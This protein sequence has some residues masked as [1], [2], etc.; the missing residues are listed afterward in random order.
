MIGISDG[1][2]AD[3]KW[4]NTLNRLRIEWVYRYTSARGNAIRTRVRAKVVVERMILLHQHNKV[5]DWG[6]GLWL[7]DE[8]IGRN[9]TNM[10]RPNH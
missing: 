4:L 6:F 9:D 10:P 2:V 8:S 7:N 3:M 5:F 1:T